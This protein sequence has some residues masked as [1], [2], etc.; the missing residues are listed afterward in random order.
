[1]E[2]KEQTQ[3]NQPGVGGEEFKIELDS[4]SFGKWDNDEKIDF[5]EI[6]FTL[7]PEVEQFI[8]NF[9]FCWYGDENREQH[10][11]GVFYLIKRNGKYVLNGIPNP[12]LLKE[13]EE[14][15]QILKNIKQ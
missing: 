4:D 7:S 2:N 10:F 1:M 12:D 9:H 3:N 11:A 6:R 5:T 8:S 14:D 15:L 13:L